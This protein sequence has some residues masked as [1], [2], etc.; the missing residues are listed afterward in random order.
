MRAFVLALSLCA[1]LGIAHAQET[2]L[3]GGPEG[4]APRNVDTVT[5][6]TAP[7]DLPETQPVVAVRAR[8]PDSETFASLEGVRSARAGT[9]D[10]PAGAAQIS[11]GAGL[12]VDVDGVAALL[13][14]CGPS[15]ATLAAL[16]DGAIEVGANHAR[17]TPLRAPN[18]G[19]AEQAVGGYNF[20]LC[21]GAG[22]T[23]AEGNTVTAYARAGESA[24]GAPLILTAF[25]DA[26]FEYIRRGKLLRLAGTDLCVATT[27]DAVAGAPLFLDACNSSP[28]RVRATFVIAR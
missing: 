4:D 15:G 26:R 25:P 19:C 24:S 11:Y 20:R 17:L 18:E 1:A 2:E 9:F 28:A 21:V 5:A 13:R 23:R 14:P 3:L 27:P 8:Q 16:N 7:P 12:C 22:P 10:G 6:D